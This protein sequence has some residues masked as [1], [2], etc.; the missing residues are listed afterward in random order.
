MI[1]GH[2]AEVH[3]Y[4]HGPNLRVF[5]VQVTKQ[6]VCKPLSQEK[7]VYGCMRP[8][9]LMNSQETRISCDLRTEKKQGLSCNR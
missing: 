2:H 9:S 8:H 7:K 5:T 6:Y 3:F 1:E 4:E